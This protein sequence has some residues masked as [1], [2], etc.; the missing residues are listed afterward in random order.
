[1][2]TEFSEKDLGKE[3]EIM[4]KDLEKGGRV[5]SVSIVEASG[6]KQTGVGR[7]RNM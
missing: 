3:R 4:E 6:I 2:E 1:M 7:P 5:S